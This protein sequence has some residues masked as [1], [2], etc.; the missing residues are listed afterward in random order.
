MIELGLTFE[1]SSWS[2]FK[3]SVIF[4][5]LH[6]LFFSR[7]HFQHP[8]DNRMDFFFWAHIRIEQPGRG[9][10]FNNGSSMF[11]R[12]ATME[13]IRFNMK[14]GNNSTSKAFCFLINIPIYPLKSESKIMVQSGRRSDESPRYNSMILRLNQIKPS[15]WI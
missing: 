6:S 14:L 10:C 13:S 3:A 4:T 1:N 7:F 12:L 11:S 8:G 5:C 2:A 15:S 9:N